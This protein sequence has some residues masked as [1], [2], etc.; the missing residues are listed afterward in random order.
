MKN[1]T[2]VTIIV[3]LIVLVLIGYFF[4]RSNSAVAP[5]NQIQT[6]TGST[7]ASSQSN[8]SNPTPA[9]NDNT[10]ITGSGAPV[11]VSTPTSPASAKTFNVVGSGF[12]FSPTTITV[13]KGDVVTINFKSTGGTHDFH[14]DAYNVATSL[15]STGQSAAPVT[16]TAD[17]TGS[18]QFYCS[19]HRSMGMVGTLIVK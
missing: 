12:S 8:P 4:F 16:F 13:N 5:I 3:I 2:I 17:K 6:Q 1:S 7:P 19:L 9:P 14:I 11:H 10:P 15:V 18:F